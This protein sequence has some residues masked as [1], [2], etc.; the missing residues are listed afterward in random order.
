G[1]VFL[2]EAVLEL[3]GGLT[4]R[5][6]I[7]DVHD[8][9]AALVPVFVRAHGLPFKTVLTIHH[10]G[11]QGSFWGL[12]FRLTNLPERFFTLHGV[13]FFGRLNFLIGAILYARRITTL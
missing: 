2:C 5:L 7:L 13:E 6:Q 4:P 3:A 10:L 12:D 1:F 9:A 8:W 11:E